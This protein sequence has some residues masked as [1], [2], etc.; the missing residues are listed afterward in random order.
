MER[1]AWRATDPGV[2][3]VRQDLVTKQQQ[4]YGLILEYKELQK[5]DSSLRGK[6]REEDLI[7]SL[8]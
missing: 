6:V 1:R 8:L 7:I 4:Q 2:T 3:R 5:K